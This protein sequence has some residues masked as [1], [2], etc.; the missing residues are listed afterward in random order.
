MCNSYLQ[1]NENSYVFKGQ[2]VTYV[3]TTDMVYTQKDVYSYLSFYH[4]WSMSIGGTNVSG[5]IKNIW[6]FISELCFPVKQVFKIAV[7]YY[8]AVTI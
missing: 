3:A 6:V 8:V 5:K 1:Q 7:F 4:D 2:I